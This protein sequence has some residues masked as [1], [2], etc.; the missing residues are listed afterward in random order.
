MIISAVPSIEYRLF[1]V[2]VCMY[3]CICTIALRH[4]VAKQ[5]EAEARKRVHANS[6]RSKLRG[7]I[8][9]RRESPVTEKT[10]E[11]FSG[12]KE[13][14]QKDDKRKIR[15]RQMSLKMS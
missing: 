7:E 6:T 10:L 5:T 8:I 11:N 4:D 2:Y 9:R 3:V 13:K 12:K 14:S 15:F 1:D